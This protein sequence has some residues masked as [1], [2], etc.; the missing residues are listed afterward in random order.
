MR[1]EPFS[2]GN[3]SPLALSLPSF[4]NLLTFQLVFFMAQ[5]F[6]LPRIQPLLIHMQ[7]NL[8]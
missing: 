8:Q 1:I 6:N 5:A 4:H 7:M 2:L 3:I